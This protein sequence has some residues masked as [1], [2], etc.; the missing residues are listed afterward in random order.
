MF[1]FFPKAIIRR[2]GIVCVEKVSKNQV[3]DGN[4]MD[5]LKRIEKILHE[6]LRPYEVV[7]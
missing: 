7:K 6:I 2:L 5:Y 3:D 4:N 1:L